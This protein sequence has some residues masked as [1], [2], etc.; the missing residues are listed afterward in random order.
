L[1][2]ASTGDLIVMLPRKTLILAVALAAC[3][4]READAQNS[5]AQSTTPDRVITPAERSRGVTLSHGV[6]LIS[7]EPTRRLTPEQ[8]D[9]ALVS[10]ANAWVTQVRQSPVGGLQLDPMGAL[11]VAA[12]Q[13]A[14]AQQQ[15]DAR[16]A[17]PHLSDADRAYTLLLATRTFGAKAT[18][19]VRMRIALGYLKQ[20]D[21]LP[22]PMALSQHLGHVAV[23]NAYY[24]AGDSKA[25]IVHMRQAFTLV[26]KMPFLQRDWLSYRYSL[27]VFADALSGLPNGRAQIDSLTT[28]LR[29]LAQAPAELVAIDSI[30]NWISRLNTQ[31]FQHVV[32]QLSYLGRPAPPITAHFWFNTPIPTVQSSAAPGALT[33]ALGDGKIRVMEYGHYGCPGCLAALPKMDHLR[34]MM[35]ANVEVWFV[36]DEGDIWGT[37]HCTAAEMATHLKQFYLE[38]KK[39]Q[40]PIAIWIGPR[41][42]QIDG[43]S[44]LQESPMSTAYQ[45][46]GFP[47]FI[48]TDGHGVVRHIGFADSDGTVLRSVQYLIAEAEHAG[49][50][51]V[52]PQGQ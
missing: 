10:R 25:V 5:T 21:A 49:G 47:T 14:L 3:T 52:A 42:A 17:T 18:D 30:Y 26:A 34:T 9:T 39:Y 12:G 51:G 36:S 1:V 35:P 29:P 40:L 38:K 43:G 15:F 46:A 7:E 32:D 13:D 16:L 8:F 28:S 45:L 20:L 6:G 33:K 4:W 19:T 41:Q 50:A 37:T 27:P 44:Q 23:A 22:A 2:L 11:A 31:E 24:D 48:I